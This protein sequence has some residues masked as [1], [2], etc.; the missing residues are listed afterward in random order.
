M[1]RATIC[2]IITQ[3]GDFSGRRF[4]SYL[5]GTCDDPGEVAFLLDLTLGDCFDN[6]RVVGTEID[7]DMGDAGLVR[8][9][10]STIESS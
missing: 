3:S 2:D 6:G 1:D 7:K 5:V 8:D 4:F 9:C 10:Q